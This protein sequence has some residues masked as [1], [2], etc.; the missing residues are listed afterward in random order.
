MN[1]YNRHD[2]PSR[3]PHGGDRGDYQR[4]DYRGGGYQRRDQ[5][6][7]NYNRR[8]YEGGGYQR[9][10][11]GNY[12]RE[13]GGGYQRRDHHEGGNY[14]REGGNYNREGGG[15]TYQRRE[16]GYNR[17][18]GGGYQRRDDGGG[19]YQ[20]REGGYNRE[21]G[22][23]YQRRD[24]HEGGGGGYQRREGGYNR[25]GGGGGYQRRDHE[26][27][28]GGYQR[29]EGSYNREGGG[30]GGYQR[31]D[32]EGGGGGYQRRE[33]GYNREGSGGYQRREHFNDRDGGYRRP[34][35]GPPR[36]GP[37]GGGDRRPFQDRPRRNSP[38]I[39]IP[40]SPFLLPEH[41][42][43]QDFQRAIGMAK[44]TIVDVDPRKKRG[45]IE[46]EGFQYKFEDERK[47]DLQRKYPIQKFKD[48]EIQFAFWPTYSQKAAQYRKIDE[49]PTIKIANLRR[50]L[51]QPN[52]VEIIGQILLTEDELFVMSVFS[53]SQRKKYMVTI[54]GKYPGEM[55]DFI[56]MLG[57]LKDGQIHYE[58]HRIVAEVQQPQPP[59][60]TTP[61]T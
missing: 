57:Q 52:I 61:A 41:P 7:G 32:H 45:T 24:H 31:R 44:G 60:Q 3:P 23:G 5:D 56:Q 10:E 15:G 35:G 59:A 8:E 16:G 33:G 28:G 51:P 43:T 40:D 42:L 20:R 1:S 13:G 46:I 14:N 37:G 54:L 53:A 34:Y 25:E 36:R 27:G 39:A 4:G 38:P 26:G 30:G 19:T 55:G 49:S 21:G 50:T 9:R 47:R 12:N 2:Q 17:E 6:S 29:R 11:G 18:G 48:R 58:S 22:G